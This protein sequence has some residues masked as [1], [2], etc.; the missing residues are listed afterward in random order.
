VCQL[1]LL[2]HVQVVLFG[3]GHVHKPVDKRA[4]LFCLALPDSQ[5][6]ACRLNSPIASMPTGRCVKC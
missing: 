6:L 3:Q 1:V 4:C 2:G 5:M